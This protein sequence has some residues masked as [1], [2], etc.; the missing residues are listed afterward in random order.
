[1]Q[2]N[3]GYNSTINITCN[4]KYIELQKDYNINEKYYQ[5]P[6]NKLIFIPDEQRNY[7]NS[8]TN[9]IEIPIKIIIYKKYIK[10]NSILVPLTINID[11]FI[12]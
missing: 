10:E 1:M 9:R 5:L 8:Y 3:P 4:N 12:E 7:Y 11:G 2:D 6:T